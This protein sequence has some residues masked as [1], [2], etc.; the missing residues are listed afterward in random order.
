MT[1]ETKLYAIT[2]S[3][4]RDGAVIYFAGKQ[5]W[6]VKFADSAIAPDGDALL[7]EAAAGPPPLEAVG[8]YVIEVTQAEGIIRPVGLRE[9]IRAF[10]PTA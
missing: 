8:A 4:L 1:T 2:A 7:A 10:G 9:E 3:R 5:T 6:S